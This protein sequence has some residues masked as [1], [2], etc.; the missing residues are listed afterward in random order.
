MSSTET[1]PRRR[2]LPFGALIIVTLFLTG[3]APGDVGGCGGSNADTPIPGDAA[4]AE[5]DF[6]D[7]GLCAN[8]CWRLRECGSL[9]DVIRRNGQSCDNNSPEAYSQC[10]RGDIREDLFP[11][12]LMLS[13]CPHSCGPYGGQYAGAFR[14]DVASCGHQVLATSC[15]ADALINV[16]IQPPTACTVVCR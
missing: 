13:R 10:V 4:E 11:R 14:Q 5:Y 15:N 7:E 1:R 6:F 12:E 2:A 8:F 16:L 9:C 3:P